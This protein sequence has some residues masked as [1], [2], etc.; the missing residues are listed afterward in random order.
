MPTID[1]YYAL[2][3]QIGKRITHLIPKLIDV[4]N[5]RHHSLENQNGK[6]EKCNSLF[7]E[8]EEDFRECIIM[9]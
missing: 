6:V 5:Q 2:T 1:P 9:V 8:L 7:F 3:Q 4:W